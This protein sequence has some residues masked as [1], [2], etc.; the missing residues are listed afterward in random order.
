MKFED[1]VPNIWNPWTTLSSDIPFIDNTKGIGNGEKKVRKEL[2]LSIEG[3]QND[4]RDLP[5]IN[6]TVKNVTNFGFR[7]PQ[8]LG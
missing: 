7:I 6:G 3:G 2:G 8:K 5:E 1:V 4:V